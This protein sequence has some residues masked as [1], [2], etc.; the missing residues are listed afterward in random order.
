[1]IRKATAVKLAAGVIENTKDEN[2]KVNCNEL[3]WQIRK[4]AGKRL[5]EMGRDDRSQLLFWVAEIAAEGDAKSEK[6]EAA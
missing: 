3:Y 2:G 4:A 5:L 1:M 6:E